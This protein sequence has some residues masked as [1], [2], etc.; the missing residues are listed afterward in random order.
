MKSTNK[1]KIL[2]YTTNDSIFTLPVVYKICK[3]LKNKKIDIYSVEPKLTRGIKVLTIFFLFGSLFKLLRL[4]N[5]SVKLEKILNLPN[6][7]LV[8]KLDNKYLYGLS[9]N[10]PKKI[11]IKNFNIYNFHCGNFINQRGSFIFF[12]KFLYDWKNLDLTFHK[13][14]SSFDSGYVVNKKR[15]KISKKDAVDICRLYLDNY[16]FIINSL[17]KINKRN[18][19]KPF[20]GKLNK[21]PSYFL[22][23]K[24]YLCNFLK[25]NIS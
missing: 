24:A 18:K 13:I 25:K 19:I 9:L 14:N 16:S 1:K 20:L 23:L 7:K 8:K 21:E 4:I 15:M 12:Y 2:I 10:F 3:Y 22:I 5:K 6:I 17:N 11:M